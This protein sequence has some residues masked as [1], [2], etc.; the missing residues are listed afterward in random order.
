M[1][2]EPSVFSWDD[3]KQMPNQISSW[4]GV[5]NYQ[6]RNLMRDQMQVGNLVFF[7]HSVVTPQAIMGIAKVVRAAYPDY[8]AFDSSSKYYDSQSSPDNPRWLMVDIQHVEDFVPPITLNELRQIK[9]LK[10]MMLL[11]KGRRLSVQPV[12]SKEWK[13][14]LA[15]RH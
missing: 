4:E 15:L 10:D 7:Y 3:L 8:F 12:T 6:A 5:R 9:A 11:Q 2:T 13:I 14:I 1:K